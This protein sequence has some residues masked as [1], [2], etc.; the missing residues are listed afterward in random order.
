MAWVITLTAQPL[1]ITSAYPRRKSAKP[2]PR[3]GVGNYYLKPYK[4]LLVDVTASG[5]AL[6]PALKL[7]NMLFK[8][9]EASGH[10]VVLAS[11][12]QSLRRTFPEEREEGG[13]PRERWQYS[14]LW[15]PARP[16]IVYV[17]DVAVG[18]SIVEI[19]ELV[20]Q[21]RTNKSRYIRES[22]HIP[23]R[24]RLLDDRWMAARAVPFGRFRIVAYS[25]YVQVDWCEQWQDT[26]T[27]PLH[28]QI[29]SVVQA[30]EAMAPALIEKVRQADR[31][32]EFRRQKWLEEVERQHREEDRKRVAQSMIDSQTELREMIAQWSHLVSVEQFLRLIRERAECLAGEDKERVLSRLNLAL[33][34]IG[35][36]DPLEFFCMWKTPEERYAPRYTTLDGG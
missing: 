32:A 33:D 34:F 5:S 16:T 30:I 23:P 13:G 7:G 20:M 28:T 21:H 15:S 17:G 1:K 10:R 27:V 19:S 14:D 29:G 12:G 4:K 2:N 9:L 36:K 24:G 35:A 3:K 25:P 6:I 26:K 31:E 8:A 18:L 11:A 22:E